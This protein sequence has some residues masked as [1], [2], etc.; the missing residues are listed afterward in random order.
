MEVENVIRL[1]DAGSSVAVL[2][3]VLYLFLRGEVVATSALKTIVSECIEEIQERLEP[4]E[5]GTHDTKN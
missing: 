1:L 4:I 5:E 2:V 3:V